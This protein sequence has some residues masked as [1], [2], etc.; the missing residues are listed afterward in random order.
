MFKGQSL[1][2]NVTILMIDLAFLHLQQILESVILGD[3]MHIKYTS[4][5]LTK[6]IN[7]DLVSLVMSTLLIEF[8]LYL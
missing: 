2:T 5:M 8:L 4:V 7:G 1:C 3:T 6:S